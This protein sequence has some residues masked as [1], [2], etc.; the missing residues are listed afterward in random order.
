VRVSGGYGDPRPWST[1]AR[2]LMW[3]NTTQFPASLQ[4]L[5]IA[6][7][8]AIALLPSLERMRNRVAGWLTVFGRV[9]LFYYLLHIPLIHAVAVLISLVRSPQ[10]T[11]WLFRNHPLAPPPVPPGY[12][13]SL[14]LLYLVFA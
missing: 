12:M 3:L 1:S 6:L 10:A 9:P 14:G 5:L 11:P 7:G 13:W 8:A 2:W 4:F